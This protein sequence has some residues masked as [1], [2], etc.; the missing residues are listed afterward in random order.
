MTFYYCYDAHCGW[1]FG[2]S[3]VMAAFAERYKDFFHFEVLSG[4]MIPKESAKHIK[5]MAGFIEDAY[6]RVEELTG[7]KFGADY[8]WH[9]QNPDE[10][11]W[12]PESLT[13]A[14]AL[15]VFKEYAP[16]KQVQIAAD[17]QKA[18][19]EEGRDL[20]DGEAYRHLLEKYSVPAEAFYQKLSDPVYAEKA[21][22]EFAL[23]RQLQVTG[24]PKL[25]LQ[26][27]DTKFYLLAEGYTPLETLNARLEN[28]MNEL[29]T[30]QKNSTEN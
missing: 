28:I 5:A 26:T 18:L 8:L 1:C 14:I 20:S 24:F 12:V 7:A 2:F 4:G 9:I 29:A 30:S 21:R 19:F 3:K 17:F 10:S 27:A 22:Y 6:K 11:D 13:P 25:L 16:E 15:S 23:C